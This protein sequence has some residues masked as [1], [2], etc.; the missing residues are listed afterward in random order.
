[1]QQG[2]YS[3]QKQSQ[4]V[5]QNQVQFLSLLTMCNQEME[6]W[7]TE[8]YNENPFLERCGFGDIRISDHSSCSRV[9]GTQIMDICNY[10][11]PAIF[12]GQDIYHIL[13]EQ[14]RY[15]DYTALEWEGFSCLIEHLEET[16]Y[17]LMDLNTLSIG[18]QIPLSILEKCLGILQNLE[19]YGIFSSDMKSCYLKQ[20]EMYGCKDKVLLRMIAENFEDLLYKKTSKLQKKYKISGAEILKYHQFLSKLRPYPLYG[21]GYEKPVYIDPDIICKMENDTLVPYLNEKGNSTFSLSD[22]YS[23][24]M[25]TTANTELKTYLYGRYQTAKNIMTNVE[26]R[27]A[28]LLR[29]TNAILERQSGFFLRKD[30]LLPMNMKEIADACDLSISTISRAVRDKYLQYPH[31]IVA[32]RDLF[33]ASAETS[34]RTLYSLSPEEAKKAILSIVQMENPKKPLNDDEIAARLQEQAIFLSRRTVAKYRKELLIP[35]SRERRER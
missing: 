14:L 15:R 5:S 10:R 31:G 6:V 27:K 21:F 13:T 9:Q 30:M 25:S 26:N 17:F 4:I 7:M 29:I 28:T 11:E 34:E 8:Q 2:I 18:S 23:H 33:T 16:G 12:E 35:T 19:P 22:Y 20:M 1:M 32:M 24:L 3:V